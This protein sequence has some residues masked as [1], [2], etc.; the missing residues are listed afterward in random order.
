MDENEP[1]NSEPTGLTR[2]HFMKGATGGIIGLLTG[3][4]VSSF[5]RYQKNIDTRQKERRDVEGV[6]FNSKTHPDIILKNYISEV[7]DVKVSFDGEYEDRNFV[8]L[9]L[10]YL[11]DKSKERAVYI[12]EKFVY[13]DEGKY[14]RDHTIIQD[15][16]YPDKEIVHMRP[17]GDHIA[18]YIQV[19][20]YFT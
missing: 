14:G 12:L 10:D 15:D 13:P 6:R 20:I 2:R 1:W 3:F 19:E 7:Y 4:G 17:P 16:D 8:E 18:K 11:P 5:N 9:R